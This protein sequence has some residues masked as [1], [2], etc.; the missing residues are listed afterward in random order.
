MQMTLNQRLDLCFWGG[1][2][3]SFIVVLAGLL[4]S[5]H[6]QKPWIAIAGEIVALLVACLYIELTIKFIKIKERDYPKN[7]QK[8]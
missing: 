2:L 7:S 1:L 5:Y 4:I 3:L 8:D 6:Y